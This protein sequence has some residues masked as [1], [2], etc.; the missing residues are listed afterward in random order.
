[1][2]IT[3]MFSHS[4][5]LITHCRLLLTAQTTRVSVP[6]VNIHYA[7]ISIPTTDSEHLEI[8]HEVTPGSGLGVCFDGRSINIKV[9]QKAIR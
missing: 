5:L 2:Y 6:V 4:P 9:S 3:S 8:S 7:P 1:M